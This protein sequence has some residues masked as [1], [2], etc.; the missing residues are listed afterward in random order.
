MCNKMKCRMSDERERDEGMG[1][2][3]MEE[4]D[5]C[6]NRKI[7]GGIDR[8]TDIYIYIYIYIYIQRKREIERKGDGKT[9]R[10]VWRN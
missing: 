5:L 6:I 2:D 4:T 9:L 7:Q 3:I 1:R 10:H 8:D